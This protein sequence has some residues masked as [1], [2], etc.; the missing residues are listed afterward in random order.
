M[1]WD[2]LADIGYSNE[3]DRKNSA[4]ALSTLERM[5]LHQQYSN[6][7]NTKSESG[8]GLPTAQ[9]T[10]VDEIKEV[11]LKHKSSKLHPPKNTKV[12]KKDIDFVT[13]PSLDNMQSL[14]VNLTKHLSFNI[15]KHSGVITENVNDKSN[16][17]K[18]AVSE[19][20]GDQKIDKEIQTS[21]IKKAQVGVQSQFSTNERPSP[22][23]HSQGIPVIIKLRNRVNSRKIRSSR[24]VY[25]NRKKFLK[26]QKK[27]NI[28]HDKSGEQV[29]EAESFEYMPG[30]IYN[31]N[32]LD[33][34]QKSK[35]VLVNK[36]SFES[37][38]GINTGSSKTSTKSFTN[39]L[40]KGIELLNKVM[41]QHHDNSNLKKKL[42]KDLV[43]KLIKSKFR[44]DDTITEFLSGLNVHS[45][46]V[47]LGQGDYN[48]YT[49][50]STSDANNSGNTSKYNRPKK[51]ILRV[52]KSV[53][54]PELAQECSS[55]NLQSGDQNSDNQKLYSCSN[56]ETEGTSKDRNSSAEAITSSEELYKKYLYA[57]QKEQTYRRHLIDK[58][59]FWKRK[60]L[61]SDISVKSAPPYKSKV[62]KLNELLNDLT[63]N[64]YD[65]GSG[66]ASKLESGS[67]FS[68]N[69]RNKYGSIEKQRSH[70]VF[71]LSSSHSKKK[72]P[73]KEDKKINF[74]PCLQDKRKLESS[75]K[76]STSKDIDC[77]DCGCPYSTNKVGLVDSAVQVNVCYTDNNNPP[78]EP[79]LKGMA[80][81][82]KYVCFCA[83]K[84]DCASDNVLI[85]KC[86][87]VA[88]RNVCNPQSPRNNLHGPQLSQLHVCGQKDS[89]KLSLTCLSPRT[90]SK[91][92]TKM[93]S[94]SSQTDLF[95]TLSEKKSTINIATQSSEESDTSGDA[96]VQTCMQ[97]DISI[98]PKISDPSLS[99][100]NFIES[101]C[102]SKKIKQKNYPRDTASQSQCGNQY[103]KIN[104][105]SQD[106]INQKQSVGNN[107]VLC[108][109]KLKTDNT[110]YKMQ[111]QTKQYTKIKRNDDD[112]QYAEKVIEKEE[113]P[114]TEDIACQAQSGP[115]CHIA[116][117]V[118]RQT[119]PLAGTNMALTI[120]VDDCE[121][122]CACK[123]KQSQGVATD[124]GDCKE[125]A[126]SLRDEC[127]KAVQSKV[128][129]ITS[130]SS[131]TNIH[132]RSRVAIPNSANSVNG[133]CCKNKNNVGMEW[134]RT[135][136]KNSNT[137]E[138]IPTYNEEI[139][140]T[141]VTKNMSSRKP[142][143]TIKKDVL[144]TVDNSKTV[145]SCCN[146][147]DKLKYK[148]FP[149][150]SSPVSARKSLARRN[151]C[152][153]ALPGPSSTYEDKSS[154]GSKNADYCLGKG[155]AGSL[156]D[157]CAPKIRKKQ[158]ADNSNNTRTPRSSVTQRTDGLFRDE[159]DVIDRQYM[160]NKC[161]APKIPKKQDF[162]N[163][164]S[165]RTEH[166]SM[167]ENLDGRDG[168]IRNANYGTGREGNEN[169]C[170]ASKIPK[171]Q[172]TDNSNK[173]GTQRSS[174]TQRF[175]GRFGDLSNN[176]YVMDR[177]E[178]ENKSGALKIPLKHIADNSN[179][180]RTQRSSVTQR[181]DGL[182]R[183]EYNV[184][185]RQDNENKCCVPK[186]TKDQDA[187]KLKN[188]RRERRSMTENVDISDNDIRNADYETGREEK[189]NKCCASK[190]PKKQIADNSKNIRTLRS[191]VT[192]NFD[193]R[194]SNTEY[195]VDS[196]EIENKSGT[197]KSPKKQDI[198][199]R[200]SSITENFDDR[201]GHG[202]S[203][204]GRISRSAEKS[205]QD[206]DYNIQ[207]SGGE[208]FDKSSNRS[209]ST[210]TLNSDP[211][212]D[213][214]KDIT[215]RYTKNE[216]DKSKR[217]KCYK[218]IMT[219]LNYL[220]DTDDT[221]ESD[222]KKLEDSCT[223]CDCAMTKPKGLK[224]D[225]MNSPRK[226]LVNKGVQSDKKKTST[227]ED[228]SDIPCSSDLRGAS[229]DSAACRL[230]NKIKNECEKYNQRRCKSKKQISS[231][232][233]ITCDKCK[234]SNQCSCKVHNRC[235]K[236][237]C[238]KAA[239]EKAKKKCIAYNLII[240]TS[241]S[242]VSEEN[243]IYKNRHPLRNIIVKVPSKRRNMTVKQEEYNFERRTSN[244]A[245]SPHRPRKSSRS[246]SLPND[247][248]S[249]EE[250]LRQ[251]Q[252]YSVRQYLERNRPDF[253][254]KYSERQNCLKKINE[255]R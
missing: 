76:P 114:K 247:S 50:T 141:M 48:S 186:I 180:I 251:S 44:G 128:F 94:K 86:S 13:V 214:I 26:N 211:I 191:S 177:Q 35:N 83:D 147:S 123:I 216:V 240:Q 46:S 207:K 28:S 199:K 166:G 244:M 57:L 167:T 119:F 112:I 217:K 12:Y 168:E 137:C 72:S 109:D 206:K 45:S 222:H 235:K 229:T 236:Q 220:V 7:D 231:S 4:T 59:N 18:N 68:T 249:A 6:S 223:S 19:I 221:T 157:C 38:E 60:L 189:E 5:A 200:S 252:D 230:L 62:Q 124:G 55:K 122:N 185:D 92:K 113:K 151:T 203:N 15:D 89:K 117:G 144:D 98:D 110:T 184:I 228:S 169:K 181:S 85:Y 152:N 201:V 56:S 75:T 61:S 116:T 219:L 150:R 69:V 210:S 95:V 179:N 241:D 41:K 192:Q 67:M 25:R 121:N 239:S 71:T 156:N 1:E 105:F 224:S 23:M 90:E 209:Y 255:F 165:I 163:L 103:K 53:S 233:S 237:K 51:S 81:K 175:D 198:R 74:K 84:C 20:S 37:S 232:T 172:I 77:Q 254:E 33:N 79:V 32:K 164:K 24:R 88:D 49:T 106:K 154:D 80:G 29:S 225:K 215:K 111:Y 218:D 146:N 248:D 182:F 87:R 36:S 91:L 64:N 102:E 193:D 171:K 54:D 142:S 8:L 93:P 138:N 250:A 126:T 202:Q 58:Q 47:A 213:L 39:E 42:I 125:K 246:R 3:N 27:S 212:L 118:D 131:D 2:S 183:D 148:T 127:S 22:K 227:T 21:L 243:I 208:Y 162:D 97:T 135:G 234:K 73:G 226:Q 158:I 70:S 161:C 174:V 78:I 173:I 9:S 11:K 176:E 190:F 149:D 16:N 205:R 139:D 115:S 130:S 17:A 134:E 188:I 101:M 82:I 143:Q 108:K 160:E 100:V 242:V 159:Y 65:D 14:H 30:H 99:D 204:D 170:C 120:D 178:I 31:Q 34:S 155:G 195:V 63:R 96:P 66:D 43:L 107:F 253:V 245:T 238:S 104:V 197:P 187:D 132:G 145:K 136:G 196:Q 52:S 10:P 133:S 153:T 129:K 140:K 194:F 40:E